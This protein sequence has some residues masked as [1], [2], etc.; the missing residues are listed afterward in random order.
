MAPGHVIGLASPDAVAPSTLPDRPVPT[1][2]FW[3]FLLK[4]AVYYA[5]P[6]AAIAAVAFPFERLRILQ[7]TDAMTLTSLGRY[8]SA[9]P[10]PAGGAAAPLVS[11]TLGKFGIPPAHLGI[12]PSSQS[13]TAAMTRTALET[14]VLRAAAT[15]PTARTF[16]SAL[17]LVLKQQGL[18]G[19]WRGF[20][21]A[22][23]QLMTAA[24]LGAPFLLPL[25]LFPGLRP[26]LSK[27]TPAAIA[28]AHAF[29]TGACC[30]ATYPLWTLAT[31]V[32]ADRST[33]TPR[34]L[35]PLPKHVEEGYARAAQTSRHR[36]LLTSKAPSLSMLRDTALFDNW[37]G[38]VRGALAGV[39]HA[40][41]FL[42]VYSGLVSVFEPRAQSLALQ[43][44][45]FANLSD[46]ARVAISP[47][48]G[49]D[50]SPVEREMLRS[51]VIASGMAAAGAGLAAY[52][53]WTLQTAA[54]V[55][56]SRGFAGLASNGSTYAGVVRTL[57][58]Q[59]GVRAFYRG[60]AQV[61]LVQMPLF[62]ATNYVIGRISKH[63]WPADL[64]PIDVRHYSQFITPFFVL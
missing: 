31:R 30:F 4:S 51:S 22:L 43:R 61:P 55:V 16:A 44:L 24:L 27:D 64:P 33:L 28:Q 40:A 36:G 8:L 32:S 56:Q 41:V 45:N 58:T 18:R 39:G 62:M 26:N 21:P 13:V 1:L 54:S 37:R 14:G 49:P 25:A 53:L 7:A 3:S 52:P 15:E 12:N 9:G 20:G 59:G 35:P 48:P 2:E 63:I 34:A 38:T 11:T 17:K 60:C 19:L 23:F 57:W 47:R 6:L 42:G 10:A 5:V 50:V 29:V 46:E